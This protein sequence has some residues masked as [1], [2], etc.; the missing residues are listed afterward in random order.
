MRYSFRI[1]EE[2][3]LDNAH[4]ARVSDWLAFS[5]TYRN[6]LMDKL[7]SHGIEHDLNLSNSFSLLSRKDPLKSFGSI[8]SES[9]LVSAGIDGGHQDYRMI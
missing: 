8:A 2:L 6:S 1:S 5:W 9:Y 4:V 3:L 7:R